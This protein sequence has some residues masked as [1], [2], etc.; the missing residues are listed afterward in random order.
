MKK[1][2][3]LLGWG[4][5]SFSAGAAPAEMDLSAWRERIKQSSAEIQ[6]LELEASASVAKIEEAENIM[7]SPFLFVDAGQLDTQKPNALPAQ[8]GTQT[9]NRN[10]GFGLG[11]QFSTGTAAKFVWKQE[12]QDIHGMSF[13]YS[14]G[15]TSSLGLEVQQSLWK[16]AFGR[17][18]RRQFERQDRAAELAKITSQLALQGKWAAAEVAYWDWVQKTT[19]TEVRKED[20][21]RAEELRYWMKDQVQRGLST[22]S[23]SMQVEALVVSRRM[24]LQNAEDELKKSVEEMRL[25]DPAFDPA[26]VSIPTEEH[27]RKGQGERIGET[28][29]VS[30]NARLLELKSAVT[31]LKSEESAEDLSTDLSLSGSYY[32]HKRDAQFSNS[33]LPSFTADKDTLALALSLKVNLDRGAVNKLHASFAAESKAAK[34]RA[35][36]AKVDGERAWKE[37]V[38]SY[39]DLKKRSALAE[40]LTDVQTRK[41]QR[42]KSLFQKGRSNTFQLVS[43]ERERSEARLLSL[44]MLIGLRKTEAQALLYAPLVNG[45]S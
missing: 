40:E 35:D 19:L 45:G 16:N 34:L 26:A 7:L 37:L 11:K 18:T 14:A 30:L 36:K 20:L 5:V 2:G 29:K 4:F 6:A 27:W 15:W 32:G 38:R 33:A 24:E 1:I 17:Q 12:Y 25:L 3:R 10:V 22:L 8:M 13:P 39:E 21:K 41:A 28:P 31:E 42:E 23:E 43:F 44:Q 9:I